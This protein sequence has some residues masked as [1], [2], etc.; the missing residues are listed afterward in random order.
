MKTIAVKLSGLGFFQTYE[1][2]SAWRIFL[3]QVLGRK[4]ETM[5]R[6]NRNLK[7]VSQ[8]KMQSD[9]RVKRCGIHRKYYRK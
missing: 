4:I 7:I 2:F 5:E 3:V 1:E 6:K 9:C 8:A